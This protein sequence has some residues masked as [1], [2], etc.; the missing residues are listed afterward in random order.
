[1]FWLNRKRTSWNCSLP[2]DEKQN[3]CFKTQK[4]QHAI[5]KMIIVKME[6]LKIIYWNS[7]K[8]L[9][10]YFVSNPLNW[11]YFIN[12]YD[13]V[14][15]NQSFVWLCDWLLFLKGVESS[16]LTDSTRFSFILFCLTTIENLWQ[17]GIQ[18]SIE[19]GSF[20][21]LFHFH[22]SMFIT[23]RFAVVVNLHR[24]SMFFLSY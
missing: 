13:I 15:L 22:Y 7:L 21:Y 8:W 24:P 4:Y 20:P 5:L 14:G 6:F 17:S 18:L 10:Y 3:V 11:K 12:M 1:M 2:V 23:N 16:A 19:V 9:W